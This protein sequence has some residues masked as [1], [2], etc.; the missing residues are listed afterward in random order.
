MRS[1]VEMCLHQRWVVVGLAILFIALSARSLTEARF[2][3]FPE[4]APPRVEIQTEAPGLSSEEVEALVTTPLESSLAGTPG[5]TAIRS[6]SVLG[7]SSIVMLFPTGTD[8]F[9]ARA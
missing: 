5:M 1:F 6:K 9:G 3:A 2:D 7:L 4:F 8:I